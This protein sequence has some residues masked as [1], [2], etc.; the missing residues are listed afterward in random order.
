MTEYQTIEHELIGAKALIRSATS[1][2]RDSLPYFIQKD[3]AYLAK[4]RGKE[5]E[6][7]KQ[8]IRHCGRGE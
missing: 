5:L 7:L 1:A 8:E 6:K 3:M 4:Q 2:E